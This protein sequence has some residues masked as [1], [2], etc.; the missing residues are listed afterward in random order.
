M[1]LDDRDSRSTG[2]GMGAV[3]S[4]ITVAFKLSSTSCF[5]LSTQGMCVYTPLNR[6]SSMNTMFT[7]AQ[8]AHTAAVAAPGVPDLPKDQLDYLA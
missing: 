5:T 6:T 4:Q 1:L 3:K 8:T 7:T 2:S